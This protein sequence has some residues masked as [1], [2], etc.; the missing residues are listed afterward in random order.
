L[1]TEDNIFDKIDENIEKWDMRDEF[2]RQGKSLVYNDETIS[3]KY[4]ILET[5]LGEKFLIDLDANGKI[6]RIKQI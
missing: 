3:E 5:P 4:S 1:D 2:F 6:V